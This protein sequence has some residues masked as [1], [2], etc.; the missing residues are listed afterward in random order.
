MSENLTLVRCQNFRA[1]PKEIQNL[2][3]KTISIGNLVIQLLIIDYCP[4]LILTNRPKVKNY[5]IYC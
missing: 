3:N 2:E 4:S 5:V 1:F